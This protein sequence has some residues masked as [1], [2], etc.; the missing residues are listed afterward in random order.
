MIEQ[1]TVPYFK[2]TSFYA[3]LFLNLIFGTAMIWAIEKRIKLKKKYSRELKRRY[4]K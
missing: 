4:K 3:M 1:T 2:D